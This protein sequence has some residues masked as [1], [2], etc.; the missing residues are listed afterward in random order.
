MDQRLL[1]TWSSQKKPE[2]LLPEELLSSTATAISDLTPSRAPV[3]GFVVTAMR[4]RDRQ[5]RPGADSRRWRNRG[6]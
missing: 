2:R 4:I 6:D 5:G 1:T 3:G